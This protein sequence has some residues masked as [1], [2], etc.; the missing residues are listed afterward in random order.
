[1]RI[2]CIMYMFSYKKAQIK[3]KCACVHN[4]HVFIVMNV[5]KYINIYMCDLGGGRGCVAKSPSSYL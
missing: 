2:M 4:L 3:N 1:M 5:L